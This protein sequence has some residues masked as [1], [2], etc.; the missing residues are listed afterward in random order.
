MA[1]SGYRAIEQFTA[2]EIHSRHRLVKQEEIGHRG[3]RECQQHALQL[4][5]GQLAQPAVDQMFRLDATQGLKRRAPNAPRIPQGHRPARQRARKQVVDVDGRVS[6][7]FKL[8]GHVTD[9]RSIFPAMTRN[10]QE[11]NRPRMRNLAEQRLEQGGFAGSVGPDQRGE[12]TA[13]QMQRDV[14]EDALLPERDIQILDPRAALAATVWRETGVRMGEGVH[15]IREHRGQHAKVLLHRAQIRVASRRRIVVSG[16]GRIERADRN[17]GFPADDVGAFRRVLRFGENG[18]HAVA[19][20]ELDGVSEFP[21]IRLGTGLSFH[22]SDD[23][24]IELA[25]EV[26]KSLVK[27]DDVPVREAIR[28]RASLREPVELAT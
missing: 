19:P 3:Q 21:R 22:D 2:R 13:V 4:P 1:E 24:Q 7:E 5:A 8:L 18:P 25:G 11:M 9:D 27:R 16:C 14:F 6:V 26:R 17:A 20:N 10:G 28:E 12:F 23:V 15:L